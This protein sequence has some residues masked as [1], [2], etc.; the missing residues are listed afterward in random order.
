MGEMLRR[1]EEF[2]IIPNK[3]NSKHVLVRS[4][5]NLKNAKRAVQVSPW[6]DN[7]LSTI[8][9][10]ALYNDI[11]SLASYNRYSLGTGIAAS[12]TWLINQILAMGY[13]SSK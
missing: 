3:I 12:R 5:Y 1:K 4:E 13:P 9:T 2:S 11:V 8:S 10:D 6:I 7:L